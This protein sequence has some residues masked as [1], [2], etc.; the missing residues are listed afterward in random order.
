MELMVN[1]LH[2]RYDSADV[3][4]EIYG[5]M[6]DFVLQAKLKIIRRP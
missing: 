4:R 6:V 5:R 2:R 3:L 1:D